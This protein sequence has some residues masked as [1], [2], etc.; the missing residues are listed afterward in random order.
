MRRYTASSREATERRTDTFTNYHNA[1]GKGPRVEHWQWVEVSCKVYDPYIQSANPDG[2]WYRLA[3]PPW[4]N[5]YYAV[6]NTFMNGDVV[7]HS[8]ISSTPTA[9]AVRATVARNR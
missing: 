3:S 6:A 2:Y 8:I 9:A 7:G 5:E 1:S 4:N